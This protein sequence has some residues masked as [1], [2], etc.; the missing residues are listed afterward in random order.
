MKC[1]PMCTMW[2]PD[3]SRGGS[4]R[5]GVSDLGRISWRGQKEVVRGFGQ[6]RATWQRC[7]WVGQAGSV[8]HVPHSGILLKEANCCWCDSC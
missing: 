4:I 6:C 2:D 1:P 3:F 5:L 8:G 7:V